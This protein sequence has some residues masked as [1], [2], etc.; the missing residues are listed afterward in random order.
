M[1]GSWWALGLGE[2]DDAVNKHGPS[3]P[4]TMFFLEHNFAV[5]SEHD[6]RVHLGP[7]LA[8]LLQGKE[9]Q[10]SQETTGWP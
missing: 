9:I 10:S 5:T 8:R 7:E 6:N 1:R 2:R 4:D 3:R